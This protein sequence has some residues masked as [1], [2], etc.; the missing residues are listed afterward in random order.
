MTRR[1]PGIA[2]T[3]LLGMACNQCGLAQTR[4]AIPATPQ[5]IALAQTMAPP[6][7]SIAVE[8][9]AISLPGNALMRAVEARRASATPPK[10]EA[11]RLTWIAGGRAQ[12]LLAIASDERDRF[13]CTLVDRK[14]VPADSMY[15]VGRLLESG[16]AAVWTDAPPGLAAA[17]EIRRTNPQCRHGPMGNVI[18]RVAAGGP[19]LLVLIE[20]VT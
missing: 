9:A 7:L 11:Q 6:C 20:C 5:R 10:D 14:Q 12:G 2:L 4:A 13:G 8:Q 1:W 15:L 3:A 19:P 16:R 17:I 18:Y